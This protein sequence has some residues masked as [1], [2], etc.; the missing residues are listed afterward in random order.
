MDGENK[1]PDTEETEAAKKAP[2]DGGAAEKDARI[3]ELEKE[4]KD[5][6]TQID[7][8]QKELDKIREEQAAAARRTRAEKLVNEMVNRGVEFA[9]DEDRESEMKRLAGLTDDAFEATEAAVK[10]I[11]KKDPTADPNADPK[12]DDKNKEK[13]KKP[14]KGKADCGCG[15]S[16]DASVRPA[17][18]QDGKVPLEDQ[19]KDGFM[20][21]YNERVGAAN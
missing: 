10:R 11:K 20:A 4:N 16:A 15:M 14:P 13:D 1:K 9:D 7:E 18:V 5:L 21:A 6:K 12:P 17:D 3:K 2:G 8:V 19:L